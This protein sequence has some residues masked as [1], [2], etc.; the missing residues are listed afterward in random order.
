MRWHSLWQIISSRCVCMKKKVKLFQTGSTCMCTAAGGKPKATISALYEQSLTAA[1]AMHFTQCKDFTLIWREGGG[2]VEFMLFQ[3]ISCTME[4]K[5]LY[6]IVLMHAFLGMCCSTPSPPPFH[7]LP[8]FSFGSER[9]MTQANW[10][11][12]MFHH[13]EDIKSPLIDSAN[14]KRCFIP[15]HPRVFV[16][17]HKYK[18]CVLPSPHTV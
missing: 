17:L 16:S 15:S 2:S 10:H 18:W 11:G 6:T 12:D 1:W 3:L 9:E 14:I 13:A 4:N 5:I 8:F 7:I